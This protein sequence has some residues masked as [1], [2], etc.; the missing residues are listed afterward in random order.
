MWHGPP[1][2]GALFYLEKKMD[3]RKI[4]LINAVTM[5]EATVHDA[6]KLLESVEGELERFLNAAAGSTPAQV[7]AS[8]AVLVKDSVRDQI[9]RAR[10]LLHDV[11]PH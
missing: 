11:Q 4:A 6:R 8:F 5:I 1:R 10:R 3:A 9:A 7:E 2:E